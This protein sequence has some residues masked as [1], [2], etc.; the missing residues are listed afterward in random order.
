[1]VLG[2][3]IR[4]VVLCELPPTRANAILNLFSFDSEKVK[5]GHG[6]YKVH[7]SAISTVVYDLME[8][9]EQE[10]IAMAYTLQQF[11]RDFVRSHPDLFPPEEVLKSYNPE[12]R[13]RGLKPEERLQGLPPSVIE[14]YLHKITKRNVRVPKRRK[15]D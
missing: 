1:M 8:K 15:S 10:G 12:E 5:F 11:T 2:R 14:G 9:Y 7:D 6:H 13:L 4:L 3:M